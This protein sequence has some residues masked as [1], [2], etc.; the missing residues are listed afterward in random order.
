MRD[1]YEVLGV[2]R[3]ASEAEVKR[4][5]LKARKQYHP[6]SRR[7]QSARRRSFRTIGQR[8]IATRRSAEFD[9][10][11]I[12]AEGIQNSGFE[13]FMTPGGGGSETRPAASRGHR[14]FGRGAEGRAA[15]HLPLHQRRPGARRSGAGGRRVDFLSS[16]RPR[17]RRSPPR[18]ENRRKLRCG[19]TLRISPQPKTEVTLPTADGR[20]DAKRA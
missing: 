10:G 14:E 19:V 4:A 12:D 1:P 17:A 15:P 2:G 13:G 9:S 11:E 16:I 20:G 6:T 7:R 5:Y 3:S 18:R 8:I